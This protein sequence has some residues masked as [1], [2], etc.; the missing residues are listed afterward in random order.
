MP[1]VWVQGERCCVPVPC[2]SPPTMGRQVP[3]KSLSCSQF[4]SLLLFTSEGCL[5]V[6]HHPSHVP[7]LVRRASHPFWFAQKYFRYLLLNTQGLCFV[8]TGLL[9]QGAVKCGTSC[10]MGLHTTLSLAASSGLIIP[11]CLFC[12]FI[13]LFS[14]ILLVFSGELTMREDTRRSTSDLLLEQGSCV[15][16]WILF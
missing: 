7:W 4:L 2:G 12:F 10:P 6:K 8:L 5:F 13:Y 15:L 9:W 3:Q 11:A 1:A 16:P 14:E